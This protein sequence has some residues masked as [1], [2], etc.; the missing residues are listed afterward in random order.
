MRNI[1]RPQ[2]HVAARITH[3]DSKIAVTVTARKATV[4]VFG[5]II[6]SRKIS[7]MTSHPPLNTR[8]QPHS[9]ITLNR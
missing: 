1:T 2:R 4:P 9:P 8:K 6:Y 3:D 7:G 5:H